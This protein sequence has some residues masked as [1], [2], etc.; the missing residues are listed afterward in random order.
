MEKKVLDIETKLKTLSEVHPERLAAYEAEHPLYRGMVDIYRLK[1]G[2]LN[3]L[4]AE[5]NEIRMTARTYHMAPVDRDALLKPIIK[6]EDIVKQ[7]MVR[8]FKDFG[9]ED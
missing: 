1:Q 7:D 2:Q 9:I 5:A 8:A 6:Q 4:R 3:R